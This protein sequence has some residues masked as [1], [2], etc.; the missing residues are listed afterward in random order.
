MPPLIGRFVPFIAVAAANSL[1][2]P[3]MRQREIEYG[4]P[5]YDEDGNNLGMS[6]VSEC[7]HTFLFCTVTNRLIFW[8][9]LFPPYTNN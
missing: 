1:N 8:L 2:I 4:V 5:V 9:Q 3:L 7:V 6:T